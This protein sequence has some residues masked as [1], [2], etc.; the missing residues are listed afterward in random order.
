[1]PVEL[2]VAGRHRG[3]DIVKNAG[4]GSRF[5]PMIATKMDQ[6]GMKHEVW[7]DQPGILLQKG[8]GKECVWHGEGKV[9]EAG[10]LAGRQKHWRTCKQQTKALG[11]T[12]IRVGYC[13]VAAVPVHGLAAAL[14]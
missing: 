14:G 2:A 5:Q 12:L 8:A 4:C 10:T 7:Q 1:M 6:D 3:Q 9:W 11:W 13:G